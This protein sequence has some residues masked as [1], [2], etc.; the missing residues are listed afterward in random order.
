LPY[1]EARLPINF[2]DEKNINDKLKICEWLGVT[3][4]I[5][6]IDERSFNNNM[7]QISRLLNLINTKKTPA[8]YL[9]INIKPLNLKDF[10]RK[11]KT[12]EKQPHI[13]SVETANKEIQIRAARDSR[14]DLLSFSDPAILKT[15]DKGVLSL[16]KQNNSFIELS[17]SPL[18][19]DNK[20]L[21]SRYFRNFYRF[22]HLAIREK[23]NYIVSGNFHHPLEIRHPKTFISICHSLFDLSIP[24]AKNAVR[25]NV[26][27]L[28]NRSKFRYDKNYFE[29][30]VKLLK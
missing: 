30:G 8:L 10:K 29:N 4:V 7:K 18:M 13:I 27:R 11:I 21:Q 22:I 14:V 15:L 20:Y 25:T 5:L 19:E 1:F 17:L 6:E 12:Y 2:K 3:H 24:Q 23:A 28:I 26:E 9:R 16:T